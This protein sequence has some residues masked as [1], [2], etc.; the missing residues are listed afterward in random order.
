MMIQA[1]TTGIPE[2]FTCPVSLDRPGRLD[3][4]YKLPEASTRP[5]AFGWPSRLDFLGL[6]PWSL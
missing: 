4:V 1:R 3:F 2:A 6:C 5:T